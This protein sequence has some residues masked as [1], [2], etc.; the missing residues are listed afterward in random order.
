ME[1]RC[2]R[3]PLGGLCGKPICPSTVQGLA[4]W[5]DVAWM[6]RSEIRDFASLGPFP[7]LRGASRAG[8][9]GPDPLAPSGLRG[10]IFLRNLKIPI[11]AIPTLLYI[12]RVLSDEGRFLEAVLQR[13]ERKL[14]GP[15]RPGTADRLVAKGGAPGGA[16]PYVTGR[17]RFTLPREVGTLLPPPRVLRH[18]TLAPP[19]APSPSRSSRRKGKPRTHCAA[20]MRELGCL[21]REIGNSKRGAS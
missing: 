1:H 12:F 9:F 17:A 19:A 11:D 2:M 13:T 20:R 3:Y 4:S 5:P 18:C 14:T 10:K 6:E 8:H 16:A 7:G 21:N 15:G